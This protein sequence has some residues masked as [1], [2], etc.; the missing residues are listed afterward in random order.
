[1]VPYFYLNLL[2]AVI[3]A[4]TL[5]FLSP[6]LS[7]FSFKVFGHKEFRENQRKVINCALSGRDVFAIMPTGAGKSLLYQV[8]PLSH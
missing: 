5:K 1:M 2:F 6:L 8:S 3:L 7:L 4:L